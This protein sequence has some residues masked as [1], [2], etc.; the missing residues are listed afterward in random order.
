MKAVNMVAIHPRKCHSDD[1]GKMHKIAPNQLKRPFN[2]AQPNT[3][4][5]GDATNIRTAQG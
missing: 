5:V 1:A 2:P 4:W 3:H